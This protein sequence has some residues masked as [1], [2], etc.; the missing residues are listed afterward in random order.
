MEQTALFSNLYLLETGLYLKNTLSKP[1]YLAKASLNISTRK[2][3]I[4]S[5]SRSALSL[6]A[7]M[8]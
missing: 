5:E 8:W 6:S 4:F 2:Y 3:L 1:S 7:I